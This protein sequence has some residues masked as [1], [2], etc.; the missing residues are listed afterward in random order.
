L[1]E[2]DGGG[3]SVAIGDQSNIPHF[4]AGRA[5]RYAPAASVAAVSLNSQI[6]DTAR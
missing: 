3:G 1:T 6:P 4:H 5:I 2:D